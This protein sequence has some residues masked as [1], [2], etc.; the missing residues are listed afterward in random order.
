ME[1]ERVGKGRE[2]EEI[3]PLLCPLRD[4]PGQHERGDDV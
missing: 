1:T 2:G 3:V 4:P